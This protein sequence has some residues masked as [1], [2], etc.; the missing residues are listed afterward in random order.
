[1]KIND[2][3]RF[4]DGSRLL[5]CYVTVVAPQILQHASAGTDRRLSGALP[6]R[7]VLARCIGACICKGTGT[8][9]T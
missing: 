4:A 9:E 3:V 1:M 7:A 2:N 5:L 8:P 6:A